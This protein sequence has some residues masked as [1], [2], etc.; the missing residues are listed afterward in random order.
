MQNTHNYLYPTV[1]RVGSPRPVSPIIT[2]TALPVKCNMINIQTH[3]LVL[4]N[5]S[6]HLKYRG[7]KMA[8]KKLTDKQPPPAFHKCV[9]PEG[10]TCVW[11]DSA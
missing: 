11:L 10:K 4:I 2:P 3:P 6:E 7:C 8:K 5:L 1:I 9:S